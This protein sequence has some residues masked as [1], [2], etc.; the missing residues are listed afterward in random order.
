MEFADTTGSD[1]RRGSVCGRIAACAI[2]AL[3]LASCVVLFEP[4]EHL[5]NL[6][7]NVLAP[8]VLSLVE[9]AK[10]MISGVHHLPLRTRYRCALGWCIERHARMYVQ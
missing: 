2:R 6:A 10:C 7:F 4:N 8:T 9:G 5:S 1:C 3:P